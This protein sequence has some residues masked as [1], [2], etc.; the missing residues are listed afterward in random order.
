MTLSLGSLFTAVAAKR[1]AQVDLPKRGSNQHELNGSSRLREFFGPDRVE[2]D[3]RWHHFVEDDQPA[4]ATGSFTF[5]DA[6]AKSAARTG[7]TEWR[8]YYTGD[9][10]DRASAGDL[11]ILARG[12]AGEVHALVFEAD[13][14]WM[15]AAQVLFDVDSSSIAFRITA[16]DE[17]NRHAIEFVSARIIEE[18]QLEVELPT[19]SD[20]QV[21][22]EQELKRARADGLVFPTTARM[23]VVARELVVVDTRDP[24]SA[25]LRWLDAEERIFRAVERLLVDVKL[26]AGFADVDDFIA[27]SLS[28]QNRRKSR[29]GYAL[30][31]HLAELFR[32]HGLRF[33]VQSYTEIGRNRTSCFPAWTATTTRL[34]ILPGWRCW[35]PNLPARSVGRRS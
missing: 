14:S 19:T 33:S 8:M 15:R 29:M 28:V 1:L 31:N 18:L 20:H 4:H 21:V 6:R 27:Y 26:R 12:Q 32:L 11:L 25:L 30:Q 22:A 7:R 16:R 2:G 5:Y 17:L 10:L 13:S 3:L 9:F 34:S 23:A 35:R 24:D